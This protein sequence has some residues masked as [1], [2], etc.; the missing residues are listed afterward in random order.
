MKIA[1]PENVQN[2]N[3]LTYKIST[4]TSV[5]FHNRTN[6]KLSGSMRNYSCKLVYLLKNHI[7]NRGSQP[8]VMGGVARSQSVIF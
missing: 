3:L 8:V 2:H 5:F 4:K 7:R 6:T 1:D